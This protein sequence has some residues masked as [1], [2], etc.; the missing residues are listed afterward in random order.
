MAQLLYKSFIKPTN[1]GHV[2]ANS[3]C[4]ILLQHN[5]CVFSAVGRLLVL[6]QIYPFYFLWFHEKQI[7][8]SLMHLCSSHSSSALKIIQR[9]I[10]LLRGNYWFQNTLIV[11]YQLTQG[12][13]EDACIQQG[14]CLF[15]FPVSCS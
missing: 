3:L 14:F 13:L 2:L 4:V 12:H 8:I 1:L 5:I 9:S 6:S 11:M 10:L 7:S 15:V